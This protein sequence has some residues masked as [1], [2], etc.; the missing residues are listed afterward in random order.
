MAAVPVNEKLKRTIKQELGAEGWLDP[1]AAATAAALADKPGGTLTDGVWVK[2]PA[3]P[4]IEVGGAGTVTLDTKDAAGA[5]TLAVVTYNPPTDTSDW[6]LINGAVA[7]R[8]TLTGTATA[9]VR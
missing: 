4:Q 9:S 6:L 8:A 5:I 3:I 2:L 1:D 7:V